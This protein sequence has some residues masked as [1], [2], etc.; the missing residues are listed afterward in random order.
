VTKFD[1]EIEYMDCLEADKP[2]DNKLV[3]LSAYL[4]DSGASAHFIPHF[5]DLIHPEP[6][7]VNVIVA[8]GSV[9]RSTHK[10]NI[11]I[12]FTCDQGRKSSLLL[13]RVL[14]IPGLNRHLFSIP[15]FFTFPTSY[16]HQN[17]AMPSEVV[18][19][20]PL[21]SIDFNL[22]HK[23]LSHRSFQ[24]LALASDNQVWADMF[25]VTPLTPGVKK[26]GGYNGCV[27]AIHARN[28]TCS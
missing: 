19:E 1:G 9:C 14:Y 6:C 7:T 23:R 21:P 24:S 5:G 11:R 10:G 28:Y 8:D 22:G 20:K 2:F 3:I 12:S 15:A 16:F 17:I 4:I 25:S 13:T 18:S 27:Q 26:C